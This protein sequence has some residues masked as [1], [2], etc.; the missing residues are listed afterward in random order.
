MR[1][2]TLQEPEALLQQGCHQM[3][4]QAKNTTDLGH[5]DRRLELGVNIGLQLW[6]LVMQVQL[7]S[8]STCTA[9]DTQK[10]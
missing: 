2:Y 9:A 4:P 3:Q 1:V 10:Q 5:S 6:H 7:Q 8:T